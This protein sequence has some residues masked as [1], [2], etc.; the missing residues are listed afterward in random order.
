MMGT[1]PHIPDHTEALEREARE[2]AKDE[3]DEWAA[4]DQEGGD[5]GAPQHLKRFGWPTP[6]QA[7]VPTINTEKQPKESGISALESHGA[8]NCEAASIASPAGKEAKGKEAEKKP[9]MG[10]FSQSMSERLAMLE[11]GDGEEGG[12]KLPPGY[13]AP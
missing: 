9:F 4:A 11:M 2:R 12:V 3:A 10:T 5:G 8:E 6:E 7:V 13:A 1:Q